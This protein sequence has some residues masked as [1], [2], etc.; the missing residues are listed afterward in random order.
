[1]MEKKASRGSAKRSGK[2]S[3]AKDLTAKKARSV[4]G[5][6]TMNPKGKEKW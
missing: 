1:M 5:G 4:K 2:R 6:M 3:A